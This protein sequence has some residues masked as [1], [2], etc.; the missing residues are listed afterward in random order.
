MNLDLVRSF[1]SIVEHGSLNKAAE[2]LRL[3]QSTLTRQMQALEH[4]IGG[5]LFERGTTGVGL[6]AAGHKFAVGMRPV[7]AQFDAVV[8]ET[9]N[10]ACG[11]RDQLRIGYMAS[12]AADYLHPALRALRKAHP[13]VKVKLLDLSP[14]EQIAALRAGELDIALLGQGGTFT[15]REFFVRRIASLPIFVALAEHHPLAAQATVRPGDLQR[16][17]FIGAPE[18]DLPGHNQW[19][20]QLGRRAGFRPRFLED[21]ESLTHGL[22]TVVT[23]EAIALLPEYTRRTPVPGVVFRPLQD[24]TARWNLYVAW[25]RGKLPET[26]RVMLDALPTE[27]R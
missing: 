9:R 2:R 11:K 15:T 27:K 12:A 14:G 5:R 22:A 8:E 20:T 4:G 25:Q 10:L 7:L 19:I 23:E 24:S 6:T 21:A 1:F 13:E 16:E 26:V 3:S 17:R 18:K